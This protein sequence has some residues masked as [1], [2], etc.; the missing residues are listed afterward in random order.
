MRYKIKN[1]EKFQ[2]YKDRKP[3]WIKLYRDIL[4]SRDWAALSGMAAKTL[5]MVWLIGS[6]YDGTLPLND[7]LAF[8]LRIK[9]SDL[10]KC[11]QELIDNEFIIE[12]EEAPK[13]EKTTSK[14]LKEKSGFGDRYVS[15]TTKNLIMIRD[16]DCVSCGSSENLE[17]DHIK[18]VSKG[19]NSEPENLQLLC[20]SCNRSKRATYSA[21]QVATHM[22]QVATHSTSGENLRS[23][24]KEI[25]K[26]IETEIETETEYSSE[27]EA[28][29]KPN[30]ESFQPPIIFP[31]KGKTGEWAL[32]LGLFHDIQ[33]TFKDAPILDWIMQARLW[34]IANPIKQKTARGMPSFLIGWVT[35]Q[36]DRPAQPRTYQTNGKFKPANLQEV[37]AKM[38]A[39]FVMPGEQKL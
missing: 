11:I 25:E 32:P 34:A 13:S 1:W 35:R 8:R 21:E 26:E 38:P 12:S 17:I 18:P 15:Q 30:A 36:N 28:S 37:L 7:V 2:H 10:E 6:E 39:G 29:S 22:A 16:V 31:T 4:D 24:E 20:R 23:L 33:E 3:L 5:I 14:E 27:L 19:G 9:I